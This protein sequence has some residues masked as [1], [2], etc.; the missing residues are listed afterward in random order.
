MPFKS[1]SQM[2]YMFMKHPIVAKRWAANYGVPK[3]LPKHVR[4][5]KKSK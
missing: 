5:V 1:S 2:R 3:N 4:K